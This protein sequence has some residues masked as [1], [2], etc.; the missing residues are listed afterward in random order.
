MCGWVTLPLVFAG[1]G[2]RCRALPGVRSSM[3]VPDAPKVATPVPVIAEMICRSCGTRS[4]ASTSANGPSSTLCPCGGVRQ[5]VRIV[6]RPGEEAPASSEA[7]ERNVQERA[8][9]ETLTP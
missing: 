6:R 3:P 8:D 4:E 2:G 1:L 7:L 5:V 9:D